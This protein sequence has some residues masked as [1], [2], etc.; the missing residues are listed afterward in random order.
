MQA[1]SDDPKPRRPRP[2]AVRED[3][4]SP[5]GARRAPA[6]RLV[7]RP[8]KDAPLETYEQPA[9]RETD[10]PRKDAEEGAVSSTARDE[11]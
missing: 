1:T 4:V 10:E 8:G 2:G 9:P 3:G 6:D 7:D 11:P 5:T